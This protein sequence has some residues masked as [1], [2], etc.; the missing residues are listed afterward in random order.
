MA[1]EE[2][3]PATPAPAV[4]AMSLPATPLG[5]YPVQNQ[6]ELRHVGFAD[7]CRAKCGGG[8]GGAIFFFCR[9]PFQINPPYR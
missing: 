7:I 1:D 9:R 6:E 8:G 3:V 5:R 2:M 4:V